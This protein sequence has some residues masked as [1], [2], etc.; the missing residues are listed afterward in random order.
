MAR[1]MNGERSTLPQEA[2]NDARK[3]LDA[4]ISES[5]FQ[6]LVIDAAQRLGWYV[7]H[8]RPA[9]TE[10]GWRTPV[11]ADGA[12]WPDLVMLRRGRCVVAELKT[13]SGR[14]TENQDR[15]IDRFGAVQLTSSGA[16]TVHVW[17]PSDW[18]EI[19]AILRGG[20]A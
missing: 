14:T 19:E 11:E 18:N 1:R 3:A 15:W 6:R 16:V 13:M 10:S 12:G 2:P 20:D 17:K 4:T 7:A 9:R 5:A 8:F